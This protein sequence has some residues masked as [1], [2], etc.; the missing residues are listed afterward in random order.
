MGFSIISHPAMGVPPLMETSKLIQI[1]TQGF[2][3]NGDNTKRPSFW[4]LL[5]GNARR[6]NAHMLDEWD[7]QTD[8]LI[9]RLNIFRNIQTMLKNWRPVNPFH[10]KNR[11]HKNQTK[12]CVLQ[13]P[14]AFW[15]TKS[16]ECDDLGG[17]P[18]QSP[19]AISSPH[20]MP[21]DSPL[22]PL[23]PFCISAGLPGNFTLW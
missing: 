4:S 15:D 1:V 17:S 10:Q 14:L 8:Y 13:K 21:L 9:S 2:E 3:I 19:L 11:H 12:I 23:T 20:W 18:Q 6:H 7:E 22:P 16:D 5:V